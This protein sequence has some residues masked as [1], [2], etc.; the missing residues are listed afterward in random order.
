[1]KGEISVN[2]PESVVACGLQARVSAKEGKH[3]KATDRELLLYLQL[4]LALSRSGPHQKEYWSS[5]ASW[6]IWP[7]FDEERVKQTPAF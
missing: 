2:V 7:L 1:M 5:F 3:I 4:P 6:I